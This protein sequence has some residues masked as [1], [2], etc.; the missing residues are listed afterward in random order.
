MSLSLRSYIVAALIALLGIYGQWAGEGFAGL[1]RYPAAAFVLALLFE[2]LKLRLRI[3][4]LTRHID[5]RGLL[6]RSLHGHWRLDNDA[7][8]SLQLL[9]L[10]EYPPGLAGKREVV[11]WQIP[12]GQ[13]AQEDFTVTPLQLGTLQWR[14]VYTRTLGRFGLAWWNRKV[15]EAGQLRVAPDRLHDYEYQTGTQHSGDRYRRT[16]GSGHEL[17][18][19]REY[20]QGDPLKAID[21]KATARS[22]KHTVRLYT[23]EQH[24]ELM[25]VIDCGRTSQ[26]QAGKLSRLHHYVNVAARLAQKAVQ[27]GDHVG[28]VTFADSPVQWLAPGRGQQALRN[29]RNML[30]QTRSLPR[31][32]NPLAASFKVR[33]LVRQRCLAVVFTD[34][35]GSGAS[36]Q[37]LKAMR[38]LYPKHLPL[39]AGLIDEEIEALQNKPAQDWLDPYNAIAARETRHA[40]ELTLLQLHRMG[41]QIIEAKPRNLDQQVLTCY[42]ML[43]DR[44]KI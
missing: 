24:L 29:V 44:H 39:L 8:T 9:S 18:A 25:L 13:Q 4:L 1:W 11:N 20:E 35:D 6:G 41:C 33:Q 42:D 43:R 32:S 19:L 17:L 15:V 27:Q 26:L 28:L 2:A 30:E 31:E 3:P 14:P 40:T 21:W 37:L 10:A 36:E 7:A 38:L 34:I 23:E 12:A 16:S 5:E 22:G